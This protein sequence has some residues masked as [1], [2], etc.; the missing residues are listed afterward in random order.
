MG[1][2][3]RRARHIGLG[4]IGWQWS[5]WRPKDQITANACSQVQHDI[6]TGRPDVVHNLAEKLQLTRW[7][8]VSGSRT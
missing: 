8:T 3:F 5:F 1:K 6:D 7:F 4:G 2:P